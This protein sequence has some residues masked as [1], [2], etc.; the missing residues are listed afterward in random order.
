MKKILILIILIAITTSSYSQTKFL[1][2]FSSI[3][4]NKIN[5]NKYSVKFSIKHSGLIKQFFEDINV[6]LTT[7]GLIIKGDIAD[8]SL[9]END[10]LYSQMNYDLN[11]DNDFNDI[12][13]LT[14]RGRKY[15][16]NGKPLRVIKS[17]SKFNNLYILNF[18]ENDNLRI[19]RFSKN[20]IPF[21]IYDI[22][23]D[24]KIIT[25]GLY[26]KKQPIKID[27]FPN[28]NV[29]IMVI[30][31][32]EKINS[33][34]KFAI[35]GL[36]NYKIFSNEKIFKDQDDSW[37]GISWAAKSINIE[38]KN[39]TEFKFTVNNISPPFAIKIYANLSMEKGICLRSRPALKIVE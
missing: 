26:T 24:S 35:A 39:I 27:E 25:T 34:I 5:G 13:Q 10:F 18:L 6:I 21:I 2:K 23:Y 3:E 9:R 38:K 8:N 19:N 1:I 28:P 17:R 22:D 16:Y 4:I 32:V 15:Y 12:F 29:Q 31:P 14:K 11:N 30:K 36:K 37:L 20:G 33:D 7:E